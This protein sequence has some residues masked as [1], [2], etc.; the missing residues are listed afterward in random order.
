MNWGITIWLI[1]FAIGAT[2]FFAIAAVVAVK[3]FWDL[4]DLLTLTGTKER[5]S[6]SKSKSN[7]DD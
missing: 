5:E 6:E 3:G 1:I 4:M 7:D 2:V